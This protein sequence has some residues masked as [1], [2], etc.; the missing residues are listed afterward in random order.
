MFP[1]WIKISPGVGRDKIQK[2]RYDFFYPEFQTVDLVQLG[3]LFSSTNNQKQ[4]QQPDVPVRAPV[5]FTIVFVFLRLF[6]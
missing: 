5:I 3:D 6:T 2:F 1:S 4:E